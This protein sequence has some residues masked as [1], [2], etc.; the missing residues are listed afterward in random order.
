M[1][2]LAVLLVCCVLVG[3]AGGPIG[4][5][6]PVATSAPGASR[7]DLLVATTRAHSPDESILFSGERR[8]G[9]SFTALSVSV[10]P[11]ER[12]QIGQ[13]QWPRSLPPNPLTEFA[14]LEVKPVDGLSGVGA[15]LKTNAPRNRR[16]LIFVHGFNTRFEAAVY[17]FAQI[18]HDSGADAAP[19]LFTWPSRGSVFEYNYDRESAN[20]SRD[21]LE[22][23]LRRTA[24]EP[25][26]GEI[27]ILAHSMG[28]WLATEA[29]RQMAIRDGRVA[30]KIRNVILAAPDLDVDVFAAQWRSLGDRP[31][32]F[33]IFAS[34]GDRALGLSRSIAG[35]AERLGR[36]DP[37][38][39]P[40]LS[41][42]GIEVID[43]TGQESADIF[44][45]AKFADNP[46]VV[47]FLGAQLINGDAAGDSSI[48]L[49]ERVGSVSMG[50]AQSVSGA[51]GLAIGAP[52][53]VIDPDMRRSYSEQANQ[54]MRAVDNTVTAGSGW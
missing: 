17:R 13:V 48:G 34:R 43:L 30:P 27:T 14:T 8:Q 21:A 41:Q 40:W 25:R 3:C 52:I 29:L 23:L 28:A 33:T 10:P 9:M 19:V 45:H 4:V 20:F 2:R 32:Q 47:R 44:R 7:I 6:R 42:A 39:K 50:V 5:L 1:H 11:D 26:V 35:N 31:P 15:W 46:E 22:A 18:V 51:A 38:A 24:K 53:A 12:R 16:V 37:D 54:F 49:G 36:I